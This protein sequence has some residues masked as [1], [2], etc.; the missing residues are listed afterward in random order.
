MIL[1]FVLYGYESWSLTLGK[2]H[3]LSVS[4]NR[5]MR[6]MFGPKRKW[7]EAGEDCLMR[8]SVICMLHQISVKVMKQGE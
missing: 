8:R 1:P 2:G 4:E 6:R 5:E 7:Q 3:G